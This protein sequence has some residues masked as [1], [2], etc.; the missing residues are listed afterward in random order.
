MIVIKSLLFSIF[1]SETDSFSI[2][3]EIYLGDQYGN[4][5]EDGSGEYEILNIVIETD[6]TRYILEDY[7]AYK[8]SAQDIADYIIEHSS[9]KTIIVDIDNLLKKHHKDGKYIGYLR[10]E[11]KNAVKWLENSPNKLNGNIDI[12]PILLYTYTINIYLKNRILKA[13]GTKGLQGCYLLSA[14]CINMD[15][16]KNIVVLFTMMFFCLSEKDRGI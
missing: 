1:L 5:T 2:Y 11:D 13:S 15:D 12:C 9:E 10:I 3:D 7:I 16:H 4:C 6:R 8:D 14:S